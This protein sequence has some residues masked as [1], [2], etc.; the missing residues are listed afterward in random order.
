MAEAGRALGEKNHGSTTE[1]LDRELF[2]DLLDRLPQ[3]VVL[4]SEEGRIL[5]WSA[6]AEALLGYRSTEMVGAQAEQILPAERLI[7]GE[8][9][10]LLAHAR[11]GGELRTSKRSGSPATAGASPCSSPRAP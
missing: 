4:L 8:G 1:V 11:A 7:A 6:G 3:A 9:A 2:F 10:R 5:F